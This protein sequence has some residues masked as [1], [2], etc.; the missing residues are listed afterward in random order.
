[1]AQAVRVARLEQE[2]AIEIVRLLRGLLA[3][4]LVVAVLRDEGEVIGCRLGA[5]AA[6]V[7]PQ[8][9]ARPLGKALP[10]Q[11]QVKQPLAG[12][13][14][15]PDRDRRRAAADLAEKLAG[16]VRRHEAHVDADLAQVVGARRPGRRARRHRLDVL[17]VAEARQP[18]GAGAFQPRADQAAAADH[19]EQRH[20]IGIVDRAQ[21][22]VD[23]AGDEHRLAGAAEPRHRQVDGRALRHVGEVGRVRKPPR[24]LGDVGGIPGGIG[25]Q[26]RSR[27]FLPREISGLCVRMEAPSSAHSRESGNPGIV[28]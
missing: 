7:E 11:R 4:G 14:D 12:I 21:Q 5:H 10:Q 2:S 20:A 27:G 1:M 25:H 13:V 26:G 28:I 16:R 24:R 9:R 22:I 6:P 17:L 18:A 19:A 23:Q 8:R 15:D 3:R